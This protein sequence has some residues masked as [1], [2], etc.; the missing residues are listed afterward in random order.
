MKTF[1]YILTFLI[2]VAVNSCLVD[3]TTNYDQNDKGYNLAGFRDPSSSLSFVSDG[4]E[5]NFNIPVRIVGPTSMDLTND[6]VVTF[7]VDPTSTAIKGTHVRIDQPTVTL[8]NADNYLGFLPVTI[9]TEGIVAPLAK[10]P[11][12][13]IKAISATGDPNVTNNGKPIN[14]TLNYGCFSD[15][16]GE[17]DVHQV[18]TRTVSGA[19]SQYDWTETINQTGVGEYRTT[20]VAYDGYVNPAPAGGTDGFTFYD[21]CNVIS[22]PQQNLVDYYSNQVYGNLPGSVD[23]ATGV[24]H[25]EYTVETTAAAGFRS[26]VSDYTPV[27]KK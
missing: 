12:L 1:K 21:V 6:I 7:D 3:D 11:L 20:I 13:V 15:L 19:I 10:A 17:Y 25:I 5:Y 24:I 4:N 16:A 22:V 18:I 23:P 2:L 26:C 9:L 8:K 14:I 27:S